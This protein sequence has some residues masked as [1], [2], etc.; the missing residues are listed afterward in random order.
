MGS[1]TLAERFSFAELKYSANI[2]W[3]CLHSLVSMH[4]ARDLYNLK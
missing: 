3:G 4:D 2:F 1:E